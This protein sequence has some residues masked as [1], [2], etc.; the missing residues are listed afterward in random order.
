VVEGVHLSL[1]CPFS[2][3][4]LNLDLLRSVHLCLHAPQYRL[5]IAHHK[6]PCWKLSESLWNKSPQLK[7]T[8]L[9]QV[10]TELINQLCFQS[11]CH[12]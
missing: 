11:D 10:P 8:Q 7:I 12:H 4:L 3:M 6:M 2:H 5:S 9:L 1:T